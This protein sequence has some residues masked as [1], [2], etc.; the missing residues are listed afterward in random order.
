MEIEIKGLKAD[1]SLL[2]EDILRQLDVVEE[3]K[4]GV[5]KEREKLAADETQLKAEQEALKKKAAEIQAALAAL[6]ERRKG[7]TPNVEAKILGQYD[8]LLKKREGLAL[9]PVKN[10]SCGGCHL[11]L[12]PQAVN[13][14]QMQERVI[15]CESCARILYYPG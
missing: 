3:A 6:E 5:S 11:E 9:V 10:D 14:I 13:E 8:R 2:E 15:V 1:K 12:P 7:Y 4:A